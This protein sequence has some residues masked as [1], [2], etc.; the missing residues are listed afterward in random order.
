MK[1]QKGMTLMEIIVSCAIYAM[2]ALLIAET[3]TLVNS[4]MRATNQL[5]RRLSFEGRNADNMVTDTSVIRAADTRTVNYQI[6]YDGSWTGTS[7]G[8]ARPTKYVAVNPN[9]ATGSYSVYD[10][11]NPRNVKDGQ[12]YT[13]F[14]DDSGIVGTRYNQNVNYRFMTFE[15]VVRDPSQWPGVPFEINIQ[16]V[17]YFTSQDAVLTDAQKQA[18]VAKANANLSKMETMDIYDFQDALL[19]P[20]ED[21]HVGP[22]AG[23]RSYT[24]GSTYTVRVDNICEV[25]PDGVQN[26]PASLKILVQGEKVGS[27][28]TSIGDWTDFDCTYYQYVNVGS[29]TTNATYYTRV[30]VEYNVA[31]RKFQVIDSMTTDAPPTLP[32][33]PT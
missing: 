22:P 5:N 25:I 15:K 2:F 21:A 10:S 7:W 28:D 9:A 11:S 12:E 14:Y 8:G 26:V 24:L 20:G 33:Y 31:E 1:K 27:S 3:M 30:V 16:I 18:A 17:P 4:T 29:G 32:A 6:R 19:A 23:S 13:A